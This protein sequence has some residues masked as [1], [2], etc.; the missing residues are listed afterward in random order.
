MGCANSK[1]QDTSQDA[2][3]DASQDTS[4]A[5]SQIQLQHTLSATGEGPRRGVRAGVRVSWLKRFLTSVPPGGSTLEVVEG[6]IKPGTKEEQCRYVQLIERQEP[7]AVGVATA[8][9]SHTWRASFRDL[10]AALAHVLDD[11]TFV[12]VDIFAVPQHPCE[13]QAQDLDFRAVVRA[14]N[15]LVLV[16]APL[17][18]VTQMSIPDAQAHR[19]PAVAWQLCAFFRVWCLAELAAALEAGKPVVLLVGAAAAGGELRFMTAP[20]MLQKLKELRLDVE[21]AAGTMSEDKERILEEIRQGSGV[22]AVNTLAQGALKRAAWCMEQREVLQAAAGNAGPLAALRGRAVGEALRA[23]AGG[24]LMG[25][26]GSLLARREEVE[27]DAADEG[28][29]NALT[30]AAYGG[31]VHAVEALLK[32]GA[33]VEATEE[34]GHTPLMAA[35]YG[36]HVQVIEALLKAGASVEATDEDGST[37]LSSAAVGG[38]AQAIEALLKAGASVE[39][40]DKDGDTALSLAEEGGH[41][42]AMRLLRTVATT[43]AGAMPTVPVPVLAGVMG[44]D[45]SGPVVVGTMMR[46]D[47]TSMPVV[48]EAAIVVRVECG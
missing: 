6:I 43:V 34:D 24:G 23:A 21:Q 20:R 10:V 42:E 36:G 29:R 2:S 1:S 22:A 27:V 37:A 3:Q 45:A 35:A 39:A 44:T 38:H 7:S 11:E 5:T 30:C 33:S 13:E 9:A 46:S 40:T 26:L 31:D 14:T 15:V 17:D 8:F 47:T 48:V 4:Q 12:W 41:E 25:P 18:E 19:V 16:G 32:A 28:G